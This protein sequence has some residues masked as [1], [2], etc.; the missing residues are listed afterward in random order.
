M[1][2]IKL[3][4]WEMEKGHGAFG[5]NKLNIVSGFGVGIWGAWGKGRAGFGFNK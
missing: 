2:L 3:G 5:F 4:K 1:G